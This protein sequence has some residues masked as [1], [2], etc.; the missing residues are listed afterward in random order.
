MAK[1]KDEVENTVQQ[2][3]ETVAQAVEEQAAETAEQ[4]AQKAEDMVVEQSAVEEQKAA[5]PEKAAVAASDTMGGGTL[6]RIEQLLIDQAK[7]NK[8]M[9]RSSHARTFGV[10]AFVI[11]FAVIGIAFYQ[12]VAKEMPT[13]NELIS[14][15]NQL[16]QTAETDLNQVL[17]D[18]NEIDFKAVNDAITGISEIDFEGINDSIKGLSE[19]V[20]SF[21]KFAENMAKPGFGLFG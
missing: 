20:A 6:E 10:I 15:A 2:A 12:I 7:Y 11:V 9:L 13:I 8:K 3:G 21:Q 19:G 16:V 18:V 17:A 5:E 4:A 14:N 1:K